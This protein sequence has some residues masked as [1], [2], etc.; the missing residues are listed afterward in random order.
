M[1]GLATKET[2]KSVSAF[3][4]S[5]DNDAKR[6]DS[7]VL[8]HLMSEITGNE[9]KIWGD[10]FIIGFGKYNYK[11]KNGKEEFEWFNVGFAP[12]K[13]K[14]T[15][16]L[17]FDIEK[18]QKLM[19]KLGKFKYGRGCLYINKLADIDIAILRL[20]I[21]KSKDAKWNQF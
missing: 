4:E 21:S 12:R 10:N 6:N 19:P 3:I 9:P 8:I 20:L 7:K 17:T 15:I 1:S 18:E 5:I 13:S 2:N 14:I 16:Y 11:R